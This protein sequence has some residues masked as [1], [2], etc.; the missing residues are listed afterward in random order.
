MTAG[1][2]LTPLLI[3]ASRNVKFQAYSIFIPNFGSSSLALVV[4]LASFGI[5][6][7]YEW[8]TP[9]YVGIATAGA[10]TV[11]YA[12][13]AGHAL[14][15]I[16]IKKLRLRHQL[17]HSDS[18]TALAQSTY[19]T[20]DRGRSIS[21][22]QPGQRE[23]SQASSSHQLWRD[24]S[25]ISRGNPHKMYDPVWNL[26]LQPVGASSPHSGYS[27]T[28]QSSPDRPGPPL[29]LGWPSAVGGEEDMTRQQMLKLLIKQTSEQAKR[30]PD[31][32]TFHID[33]PQDMRQA[34]QSSTLDPQSAIIAYDGNQTSGSRSNLQAISELPAH[35]TRYGPPSSSQTQAG[36]R[37][38]GRGN[39]VQATP[40]DMYPGD[41]DRKG[42]DLER[43][44]E[45]SSSVPGN[46]DSM[47]VTPSSMYSSQWKTREERRREIEIGRP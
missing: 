13:L 44:Q 46:R 17:I 14:Y 2:T 28:N 24:D 21:T 15:R 25:S 10:G 16:Q 39:S 7:R 6:P 19:E 42:L 8:N 32:S 41:R 1:F 11:A 12:L 31:R 40:A 20:P 9:A 30:N 47:Q 3:F 38:P 45:N 23:H 29:S 43:R 35:R 18:E 4:L 36:Q 5:Y 34:L 22:T 26:P 33:L 27:H 37:N